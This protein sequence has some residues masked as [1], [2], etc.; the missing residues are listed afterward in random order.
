MV[1]YKEIEVERDAPEAASDDE[2]SGSVWVA[3]GLFATEKLRKSR[4][5][6]MTPSPSGPLSPTP[7]PADLARS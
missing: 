6:R 5:L 2:R 1:F 7:S 3:R 4:R